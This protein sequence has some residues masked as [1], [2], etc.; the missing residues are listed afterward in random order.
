[1]EVGTE[2]LLNF[3]P[4]SVTDEIKQNVAFILATQK[5]TVPYMRD[6]GIDYGQLDTHG[7]VGRARVTADVIRAIKT[8]E[9][10]A[11]VERVVWPDGAS[12]TGTVSPR[13][14]ITIN[15]AEI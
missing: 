6:F 5:G 15:D 12:A 4:E 11:N 7:A 2:Y 10:R 14:I 1:M 8:Y 3:E 9:P 13:V